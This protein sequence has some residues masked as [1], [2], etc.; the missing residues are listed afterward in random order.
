M[1]IVQSILW[2]VDLN[3]SWALDLTLVIHA[4]IHIEVNCMVYSCHVQVLIHQ[5]H[6]I[7]HIYNKFIQSTNLEKEK[8]ML[9]THRLCNIS[10]IK[11]VII[12]YFSSYT[13]PTSFFAFWLVFSTFSKQILLY[14]LMDLMTLIYLLLMQIVIYNLKIHIK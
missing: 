2:S 13:V 12:L 9:L 10:S 6:K 11:I 8:A 5:I 3:H 14:K 4:A 1:T 7:K